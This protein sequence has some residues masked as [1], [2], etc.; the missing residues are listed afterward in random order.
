M[1]YVA[2][3]LM[4]VLLL[5]I[6]GVGY[7]Y[8]TA[9]VVA[10]ST[11]VSFVSAG[12]RADLVEDYRRRLENGTLH[13]T[14]FEERIEGAPEDY[15]FLTYTV[16]LRNDCFIA[17]D[18]VE[19]QVV[20]WDGFDILQPGDERA[21]ALQPRSRGDLSATVLSRWGTHSVREVVITYYMW[22]IPFTMRV[23]I[24]GA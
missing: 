4:L 23:T 24:A 21:R 5:A 19:M 10:E 18:M 7:V 12:E 9:Q 15:L 22:G 20:P 16:R 8:V 17:A 6:V 11:M 2:W 14:V 13:G 3:L 1:K